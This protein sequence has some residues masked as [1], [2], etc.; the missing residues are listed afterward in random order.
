M[1]YPAP[2]IFSAIGV[3]AFLAALLRLSLLTGT[4]QDGGQS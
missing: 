1:I 4:G 3:V 2:V